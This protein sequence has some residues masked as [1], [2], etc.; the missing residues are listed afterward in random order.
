[1]TSLGRRVDFLW[2]PSVVGSEIAQANKA[3]DV[4]RS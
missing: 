4:A 1:M 2:I 3:A